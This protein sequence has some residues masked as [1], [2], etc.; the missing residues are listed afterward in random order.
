MV[1]SLA[2]KVIPTIGTR[3]IDGL[4]RMNRMYGFD[5]ITDG[6]VVAVGMAWIR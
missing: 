4:E 2:Y 1:A 5:P 6:Q 3:P